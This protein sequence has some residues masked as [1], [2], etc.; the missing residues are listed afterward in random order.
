MSL[1]RFVVYFF[2]LCICGTAAFTAHSS[3]AAPLMP[4]SAPAA[5]QVVAAR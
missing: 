5:V 3:P 4:D 2:A 1:R